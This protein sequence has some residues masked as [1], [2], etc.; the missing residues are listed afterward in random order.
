LLVDDADA[1]LLR[2]TQSA[3]KYAPDEAQA[4]AERQRELGEASGQ[5]KVEF[6]PA[7]FRRKILR[8]LVMDQQPFLAAESRALEEAFL[9]A[10]FGLH[11]NSRSTYHR[12]LLQVFEE[13]RQKFEALLATHTGLFNFTCDAWS[14]IQQHEFLGKF[15]L[16]PGWPE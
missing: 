15:T 2:A 6:N 16:S 13:E 14:D 12:F 11:L 3:K 8:W 9:E 4:F 7:R 10:R 1:E 5:Q